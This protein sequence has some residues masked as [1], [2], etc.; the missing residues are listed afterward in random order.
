MGFHNLYSLNI[1]RARLEGVD[2]ETLVKLCLDEAN[3][4][5]KRK[6]DNPSA[7]GYEDSPLDAG[8]PVVKG[9]RD[10]IKRTIHKEIEPTAQEGE[11]WAHVLRPGEST[12]IHSHKNKKDWDHL[13]LSWVYYPQ[14]VDRTKGDMGGKIVFQTH[15]GA[16]K[17]ISRDFSPS[18]GDF[19]IFPSWLNHFTTRHVGDSI[20]ISISGN[21]NYRDEKIYDKVAHDPNTGIKK[22]TGF[23]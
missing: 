2:N 13:G 18:V 5:S 19:I 1:F 10:A 7:T 11:I 15:I 22:L 9:L 3:D 12:Q 4:I 14:M 8:H 23:N 21:Y 20:R 16:I 6:S 17:T